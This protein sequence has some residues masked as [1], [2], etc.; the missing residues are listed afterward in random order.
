MKANSKFINDTD[1]FTI[2]MSGLIAGVIALMIGIAIGV[3]VFYKI[4]T[5]IATGSTAGAAIHT[6]VNT[7][8]QTVWTLMPIVA[9]IVIASIMIGVVTKFGSGGM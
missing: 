8:M 7:S 2:G 5:S 4:N 3:L 9:I 6:Q 1:A